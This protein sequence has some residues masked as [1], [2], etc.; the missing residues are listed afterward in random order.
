M[1]DTGKG[2]QGKSVEGDYQDERIPAEELEDEPQREGKSVEAPMR[3][4]KPA[5]AQR[6]FRYKLL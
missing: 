6:V 4:S 2:R 5:L 3:A 1:T